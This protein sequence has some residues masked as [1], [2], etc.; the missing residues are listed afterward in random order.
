MGDGSDPWYEIDEPTVRR[1]DEKVAVETRWRREHLTAGAGLSCGFHEHGIARPRRVIREACAVSE[2]VELRDAFEVRS[3]W[4]AENRRGPDADLAGGSFPRPTHPEGQKRSIRREPE[5]PH[6][7]VVD[8]API[9]ARDVV[10]LTRAGLRDPHIHPA[11]AI[12]KE[13]N[14]TPVAR[15]RGRLFGTGKVRDFDHPRVGDRILPERVTPLQLPG[16]DGARDD[17]RNESDQEGNVHPARRLG[18]F[19]RWGDLGRRIP[20][21]CPGVDFRAV[22]VDRT[23]L[24]VLVPVNGHAF[25]FLPA[26]HGRDVPVEVCRDLLP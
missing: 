13:R 6:G 25:P 26:L 22:R 16:R 1:P 23:D 7:R 5:R 18:D 14:E 19:N 12:R 4:A 11:V 8:L 9:V 21:S 20:P 24:V 10:E 2:P 17:G 3:R 15:H